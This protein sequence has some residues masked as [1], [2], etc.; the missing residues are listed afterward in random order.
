M[1]RTSAAL[2]KA[3]R[4]QSPVEKR[5]R[6]DTINDTNQVG[7][8]GLPF[9]CHCRAE[10][11]DRAGE[12]R[13]PAPSRARSRVTGWSDERGSGLEAEENSLSASESSSSV[14]HPGGLCCGSSNT[15]WLQQLPS[16][17][18]KPGC[19]GTGMVQTKIK[20]PF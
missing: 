11:P 6:F 18:K 13:S 5:Y 14:L 10:R 4:T 2:V 1:L 17:N 12:P 8:Q 7:E 15:H 16:S 3:G 19:V 9:D 20:V